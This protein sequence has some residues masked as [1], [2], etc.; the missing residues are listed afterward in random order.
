[1]FFFFDAVFLYLPNILKSK[2]INV[3][4]LKSQKN[5]STAVHANPNVL[6][7]QFTKVEQNGQLLTELL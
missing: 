6:I 4:L 1:M 5:A 3:W 7:M 2:T